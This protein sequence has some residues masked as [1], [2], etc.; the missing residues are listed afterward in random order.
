M[1][2]SALTKDRVTAPEIADVLVIGGGIVGLATA[3]KIQQRRPGLA[4][5]VLEK[6][7]GVA[8][9]EFDNPKTVWSA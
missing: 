8:V 7:S 3:W 1:K 9:R 6:E 5:A 4:V 2:D